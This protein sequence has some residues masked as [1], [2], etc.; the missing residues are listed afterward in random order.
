MKREFSAGGIV[1]NN[2]G[3]VLIR[4]SAGTEY[5]SFPKGHIDDGETTGQAALREVKE[6]TGIEAEIS[7]KVGVSKYIYTFPK[8]TKIFKIVTFYLMRYIKG[9]LKDHDYETSDLGWFEPA[10]AL[11]MLSFSDDKKLLKKALEII[12]TK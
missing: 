7:N 12:K 3:R 8:G 6:E 9:N 5:W 1:F 10:E 4:K 11:K 2:K